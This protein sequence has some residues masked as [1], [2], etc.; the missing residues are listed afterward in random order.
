MHAKL[1]DAIKAWILDYAVTEFLSDVENVKGMLDE[2]EQ[3]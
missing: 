2:H 1:P 3:G